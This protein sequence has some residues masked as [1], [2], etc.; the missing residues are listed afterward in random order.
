[1]QLYC[2]FYHFQL[3][4]DI[5]PKTTENFRALCTGEK[6]FGYKGCIFYRIIPG[7][8]ACVSFYQMLYSLLNI[9]EKISGIDEKKRNGCHLSPLNSV[10]FSNLFPNGSV[11]KNLAFRTKRVETVLID[12]SCKTWMTIK[13]QEMKTWMMT[14][15]GVR[16]MRKKFIIK[17]SHEPKSWKWYSLRAVIS[18]QIMRIAE[19]DARFLER[20]ISRMK[21]LNCNTTHAECSQWII[22][23]GQIQSAHVSSLL[24]M[25]HRGKSAL[26]SCIYATSF[27]KC[28]KIGEIALPRF[29]NKLHFSGSI[30]VNLIPHPAT[31][32]YWFV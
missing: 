29:W 13:W 9:I 32:S 28:Y 4:K 23:D 7:F 1:M 10:Y 14:E 11:L 25:R 15:V 16:L 12:D 3:R 20:N 26:Y 19:A 27:Q 24:L 22:M 5:C 17:Y 31:L 18:R 2:V 30:S 8:C 6:G 21:I